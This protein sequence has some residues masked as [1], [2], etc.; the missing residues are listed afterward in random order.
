MSVLTIPPGVPFLDALARGLLARADDTFAL[1]D[2]LVLVPTRRAARALAEAFLRHSG[3]SALLLPRLVPLGDIDAAELDLG[4]AAEL[5]LAESLDLPPAI[6]EPRRQ[7]LLTRLIMAQAEQRTPDHAARLARELARLLDQV[8]TEGLSFAALPGLVPED[9]ARHWQ[10]T[11]EF[12]KIIS[13]AWPKILDE[14]G[15]LDPADRRAR[16]TRLQAEAWRRAP[17]ATPVI[18]AGSTGS[19]PATAELMGVVAGLPQGE[20]VLPGLD[21][22]CDTRSWAAIGDEPTHPQHMLFRLLAQLGIAREQVATWPIE[23]A[24]QPRAIFL[25]HALKPAA[26][27]DDWHAE[28]APQAAIDGLSRLDLPTSETEARAIALVLREALDVPGRTAMLVTP[29]RSLGR[30]VAA[31][32]M[33]WGVEVDDSGGRPLAATLPGTMLRLLL[34]A[35]E[36]GL[37]PVPLLALLKHPLSSGGREPARFR[38][39]A[40]ALEVR[41]L[42]G[43]RPR[44]G[45]EGLVEALRTVKDAEERRGLLGFVRDLG[46]RLAPLVDVLAKESIE[47]GALLQGHMKAAENLAASAE[48]SGADRLWRGEAGEALSDALGR[49]VDS[50]GAFPPVRGGAYPSLYAALT[51]GLV[52]R[53]LRGQHPRLAILGPLEARL[54]TAD[55]VVLGSLN[56]GSWPAEPASDPWLSRPMRARFGLPSPERRIGLSAHD[57]VE[58]ASAPRV[59]LTRADRVESTPTV[60][61]RWLLRLDVALGDE[62]APRLRADG[63]RMRAWVEALDRPDEEVRIKWPEPRPPLSARPTRLPVTDIE[64]LMRDPYGVYARRILKL[65]KLDP[66]DADPGAA[67]RGKFIHA[68]LDEFV[69]T[70]PDALPDLAFLKLTEEIGRE[71]FAAALENPTVETF[72]WPRFERIARWFLDEEERRRPLLR[73]STTE[74]RGEIEIDGFT[75]EGR[76][77]RIDRLKT[78]GLVII[79]YKTGRIPHEDH[80]QLGLAPQLPLEALIAEGGKFERVDKGTVEALQYWRLTGGEPPGE[81]TPASGS[82]LRALIAA[83]REGLRQLIRHFADPDTPYLCRPDPLHGP[84]F[85]DYDHLARVK[86]WSV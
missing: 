44:A 68:A 32:M 9:L 7:L 29:D 25:Q 33:R 54:Q 77:D 34:D 63:M 83:A 15:A 11:V 39:Y 23:T 59:V 58:L 66:I 86:E 17:P 74:T 48:D 2:A 67:D 4:A 37:A 73:K 42:R 50:A 64:K 18:V 82:E 52:V 31:E 53:P 49:L 6:E 35:A 5:G 57:F 70:Y 30:R 47:L 79:D 46:K 27:S 85:S 3:G 20:L 41:V 12:L 1:A 40:R 69:R 19:I 84:Y 10:I 45:I 78:G 22:A 43:P 14:E 36:S 75:L 81:I 71:A 21:R 72:W 28:D 51:D 62:A 38:E 56:E 16:L 60:A 65:K 61:S 76:A 13:E 26:T 80:V 24:P 8:H 55:V